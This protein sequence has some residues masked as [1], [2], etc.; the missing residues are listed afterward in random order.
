MASTPSGPTPL[1]YAALICAI[2][3]PLYVLASRWLA[4]AT[5]YRPGDDTFFV[6]MMAAPI[7][8]GF[9]LLLAILARLRQRNGVVT[10]A[11]V[12][13]GIWLALAASGVAGFMFTYSG[14]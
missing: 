5:S 4:Q 3:A 7:L 1:A 10:A 8:A 14:R 6:F 11:L 9:G 13:N 2:A 12:I